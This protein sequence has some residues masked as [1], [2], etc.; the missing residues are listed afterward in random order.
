[1]KHRGVDFSQETN[2]LSYLPS[3]GREE[4]EFGAFRLAVGR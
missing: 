2:M 3:K 4:V 1:M